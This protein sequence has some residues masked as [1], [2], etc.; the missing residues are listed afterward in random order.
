MGKMCSGRISGFC[1]C[2]FD[3]LN[4]SFWFGRLFLLNGFVGEFP[5]TARC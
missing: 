4:R 5:E 2:V 3:F 1:G